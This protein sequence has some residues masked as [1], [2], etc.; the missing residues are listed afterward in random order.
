MCA[1]IGSSSMIN[2]FFIGQLGQLGGR[3]EFWVLFKKL[4]NAGKFVIDGFQERRATREIVGLGA[5]LELPEQ[6]H[7]GHH[8][9][10]GAGAGAT[11]RNGSHTFEDALLMRKTELPQLFGRL[12]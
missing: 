12:L 7:D 1:T 8:A 10:G 3:K 11:V 5:M 4:F 2:I 6:G 9:T